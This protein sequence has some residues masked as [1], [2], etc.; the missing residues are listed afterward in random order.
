MTVLRNAKI[1][2]AALCALGTLTTV[3]SIAAE[4][5][6]EFNLP[7]QPVADALRSIGRQTT[8]SILFEPKAV[9]NLR[10]PALRGRLSPEEAIKRVLAG[11]KLVV[12]P[13]ATNSVVVTLPQPTSRTEQGLS[14]Q[15]GA[16]GSSAAVLRLAQAE[17]AQIKPAPQARESA[18]S[19]KATDA[20]A[21]DRASSPLEEIVVTANRREQR[22]VEVPMSIAAVT[23]AEMDQ[24]GIASLLDLGRMVPGLV[25][26][27]AAPGTSRIFLR[28]VTNPNN[29]T[30]QVGIYL[31]EI[32]LTG[33]SVAQFDVQFNDLERVE[34]LRGPQG[35]LY[36]QGSAGG[37]VRY[38]TRKPDLEAA[39]AELGVTGYATDGGD[40][41]EK[42][43]GVVNLPVI[44]GVL[45]LRLSGTLAD[46]GGWV[47][48][49]DARRENI[50]NQSLRNV[51]ARALWQPHEDFAVD[52]TVIIHR[53][54]GDGTTNG[55]DENYDIFYPNGDPLTR[56]FFEDNYDLYNLTA[57]YDF[58]AVQLL[59]STSYNEAD[60][61][62]A[63]SRFTLP[64]PE[65]LINDGFDNRSFSQEIRLT[66]SDESKLKW[67]LGGF[68]TDDTVDRSLLLHLFD[69]GVPLVDV[70]LPSTDKSETYSVFGDANYA[71]TQRLTLGLGL[72]YFNDD[73]VSE[74]PGLS[75]SGS[76]SSVDPRFYLSYALSDRVSLYANVA[77]GF[78]SGGFLGDVGGSTFDPEKVWSYEIGTKGSGGR[79]SWELSGYYGDYSDYQA[80]VLVNTV[81]GGV[82]NAGDAEVKGVDWLLAYRATDNLTL[83]LN[84]NVNDGKL[85]TLEPGA[86][87]NLKGDRLDFAHDYSVSASADYRFAWTDMPGFA[88]VDYNQLG[89]STFTE[90]TVGIVE[91][92]TDTLRFLNARLGLGRG[93]WTAELFGQNLL[94]EDGQ[95]EALAPL[96]L[97]NRPQPR[98]YGVTIRARFD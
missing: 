7:E 43:N 18:S 53:N 85:V 20:A 4:V 27:A 58:G 82:A 80:F 55:T 95:Q 61:A 62:G 23:Q 8:M 52:A 1:I 6:Y 78:R 94:G 29:L 26:S 64:G 12:E 77:K 74:T 90:R 71:V 54:D 84:G 3:K 88:R 42:L 32:P 22:L 48:Q 37:T 35:T 30:S 46:I 79:M 49:P 33:P 36:G 86:T 15:S 93:R 31:D 97:G 70:P 13:T 66:S 44:A 21:G 11:T 34:V 67:V 39:S 56:Q 63:G 72:R 5:S 25:V 47:D 28:G 2:A 41:S 91:V 16:E 10:A 45:G 65:I 51:R 89:P 83:Q 9:E 19:Q 87:A 75:L 96:G 69:A 59:S 24:R 76:F 40:F 73:R 68:Y 81:V 57:T 98:T 14:T 17:S 92:P 38:I 60:K 50:N